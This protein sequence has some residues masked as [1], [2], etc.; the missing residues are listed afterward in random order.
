MSPFRGDVVVTGLVLAIPVFVLAL[1][2][3]FT[4]EEV[5]TR[6]LW[7]LAAGWAAVAVIRFAS[8]P[9]PPPKPP[10]GARDA[11]PD[12]EPAPTA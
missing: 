3:E 6:V 11:Q 8:T 10:A 1:R 2:G 5:L 9:P 7:C 4:A 12:S